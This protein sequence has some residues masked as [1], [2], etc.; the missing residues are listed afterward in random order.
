M[1]GTSLP[2]YLFIRGSIWALR[3][4]TPLSIFYCSFCIAD[5]PVSRAGKALLGYCA[6]ETGF[7]L[8]VYLPRKR[9]LQAAAVHPTPLPREDRKEL[10][11]R[12]WNQIPNPEY[13]LSKWMSG[14]KPKD[15][16]RD[17]VKDFYR[18]AFLNKGDGEHKGADLEEEEHELEEYV[19]GVQTL[20]G[21][22]IEP[23]RGDAQ[24]LRLTTDNVKMLHRPLLWYSIVGLVDTL[25]AMYLY[26]SGFRLHRTPLKS[27]LSVFPFRICSLFT[28]RA[29]PAPDFSYWYR[30]HTSKTRLP[31]LFIHGISMGLYSYAQFLSE[32]NKHDPRR[33]DD[34]DIG[35][36]AIEIMPISF[37]ITGPVI[38][39]DEICR[40]VNIILERH[41]FSKVVLASHSYGSV[42][43]THLLQTPS[44][45]AKIGPMLLID[46]VTFLLHLPDVA[47]NFTAREPRGANEWQLYYFACTDMMVA[48]TLARHFFW[49]QNILWK[50][51][52]RR[53]DVTV[54]LGGRDQI[55]DA[56]M[57]GKYLAG[58]DLKGENVEW[59]NREWTGNGLETMWFPT[60]DHAQVFERKD[61][62]QK[63]GDVIRRYAESRG[64]DDEL[65]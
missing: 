19:D 56:Q 22:D 27:W 36:I 62:R 9:S 43:T 39:R 34:G 6:L 35:I 16:R 33:S 18:W 40:Q 32:I 10:F 20:L 1:I 37:R 2:E 55:I 3:A 57:V 24:A 25:T 54:S 15:V 29:S 17:N 52:V 31:V 65:P 38:S 26:Y 64:E 45:A 5:P 59:K 42:I 48:H 41:G 7:W 14:A 51:D 53:H 11:W 13:Y 30:P 44:T 58:V 60:C 49:S 46:P 28:R 23:G 4:I 50:E 63:L 21:R 12:S 61:G 47:Y 8:L